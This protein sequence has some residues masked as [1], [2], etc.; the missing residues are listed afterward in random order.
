MTSAYPSPNLPSASPR[1]ALLALLILVPMPSIGTAGAMVF[2]A[3]AG[4][5]LGQALYSLAKVGLLLFPLVWFLK[6]EGGKMQVP[7]WDG[8][9]LGL[10]IA[11]GLV[12]S[13]I[14][15]GAYLLLGP[16]SID[17]AT[18]Q[19]A[20]AKSGLDNRMVFFGLA[21]YICLVNAPLEEYVWRWFV[22]RQCETLVAKPAAVVLA[23]LFF[24]VHHVVALSVQFDLLV[25]ALCSLGVFVGGCIWSWFYARYRSVWPGTVSHIIVDVAIFWVAYQLIFGAG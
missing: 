3:T 24:T 20:A 6:A 11:S 25:T 7:S 5:P 16:A 23:A 15:V 17:P 2:E 14:I 21:T 12:I 19:A 9:G 13:A 1:L 8:R 4:T 18:V 22:Y 10:G